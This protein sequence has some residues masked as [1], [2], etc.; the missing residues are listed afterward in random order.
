MTPRTNRGVI[1]G[2]NDGHFSVRLRWRGWCKNEIENKH[3]EGNTVRFWLLGLNE[4]ELHQLHPVDLEP[5]V[6]VQ[7][8]EFNCIEAI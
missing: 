5:A 8:S 7:Q 3:S 2:G 6:D 4:D 1:R